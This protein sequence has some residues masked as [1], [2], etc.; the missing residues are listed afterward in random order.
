MEIEKGIEIAKWLEKHQDAGTMERLQSF[1]QRG[2]HFVTFWGHY[3]AGKSRLI[4]NLLGRHILPVQSRETT[5]ALT[6][7][8]YGGFEECVIHFINGEEQ[9]VELSQL[10]EIYQ[11]TSQDIDLESIDYIEVFLAEKVLKSGMILVDTPG[12]NTIIQRHQELAVD[13]IE[14]SGMIVYVLGT[15]PTKVDQDFISQIDQCGIDILFVRTKCDRINPEEEDEQAAVEKDREI[16]QTMVS[17]KVEMIPVSNEENSHWYE[18]LSRVYEVLEKVSVNIQDRI[19]MAIQHRLSRHVE[20]Y[21][22]ELQEQRELIQEQLQGGNQRLEDEIQNCDR[23]LE[24]LQDREEEG[25]ERIKSE[26]EFSKSQAKRTLE[27][28]VENSS[29]DL[30]NKLEALYW[31]PNIKSEADIIYAKQAKRGIEEIYCAL[32]DCFNQVLENE[33]QNMEE[34]SEFGLEPPQTEIGMVEQDNER[35]VTALQERNAQIKQ[36]LENLAAHKNELAIQTSNGLSYEEIEEMQL[37]LQEIDKALEA[38]P[39]STAMMV[40]SPQGM[41]PSEIFKSIGQLADVAML[42]LPGDIWIQG[43]KALASTNQIG[44]ALAKSS[45]VVEAGRKLLNTADTVR[46][47]GFL[48]NLVEQILPNRRKERLERESR[49]RNRRKREAVEAFVEDTAKQAQYALTDFKESKRGTNMFDMFSI[50]YWAEKLG[51]NFDAPPQL[52]IDYEMEAEKKKQRAVLEAQRNQQIEEILQKRK[53]LG[54]I[55]T[56]QEEMEERENQLKKKNV[57]LQRQEMLLEEN[58]QRE[59]QSR[60]KRGI[61]DQYT[62]YFHANLEKISNTLLTDRINIAGRNI[63]IYVTRQNQLLMNKIDEKKTQLESLKSLKFQGD[64]ELTQRLEQCEQYLQELT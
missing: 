63:E 3:S 2:E 42:V 38:I 18:N 45:Y 8:R 34:F 60:E 15:S 58:N 64:G 31:S 49:E 17:Q 47:T 26:I 53:K 5:A 33:N 50:A 56:Y 37:K 9:S 36:E 57:L 61:V 11:N 44:G 54:L 23:Q 32:N 46:D 20:E 62:E 40:S 16:L 51:K 13:A 21:R 30:K 52:E 41:Q 55:Q 43:A 48:M 6:Y 35:W 4:N 39:S 1:A 19:R 7:I 22:K 12:I 25:R 14:Q 59:R 24:R 28:I 29:E 27:R 10:K